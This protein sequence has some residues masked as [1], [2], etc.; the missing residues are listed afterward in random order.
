[1]CL[2]HVILYIL[3]MLALEELDSTKPEVCIKVDVHM[4]ELTEK[5]LDTSELDLLC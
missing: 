1:M 5:D 4:S 3:E 2:A